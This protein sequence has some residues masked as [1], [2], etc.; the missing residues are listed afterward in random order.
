MREAG[1]EAL[2][3]HLAGGTGATHW[4]TPPEYIEAAR[5]VLGRIDLD[6]ATHP[7]AQ[8]WIKARQFYTRR[9]NGLSRDW[10]G[11]VWLNPPYARAEIA[12]F[13]DKLIAD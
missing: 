12:P 8:E 3:N 4:L 9:D 1:P 6:P 10:R 2:A 13:I 5:A 11:R 7:E